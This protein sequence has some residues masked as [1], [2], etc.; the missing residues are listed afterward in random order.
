MLDETNRTTTPSAA[1]AANTS[2]AEDVDYVSSIDGM[3][4]MIEEHLDPDATGQSQEVSSM[5][6][7][8]SPSVLENPPLPY[9]EDASYGDATNSLNA[10]ISETSLVLDG[11]SRM[12]ALS[13]ALAASTSKAEDVDDMVDMIEDH[14]DLGV[15]NRSQELSSIATHSPSVP[16]N[17]AVLPNTDGS[18][19]DVTIGLDAGNSAVS[20]M[21]DE[22]DRAPALSSTILVASPQ[23]AH[24]VDMGFIVD[25]SSISVCV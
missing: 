25:V 5:A 4:D 20:V 6:A 10:G 18:L 14:L 21:L 8:D 23:G 17:V 1:V 24:N 13:T 3:V 16:E 7:F 15:S 19:S 22:T 12:P 9:I 2:E 11:T